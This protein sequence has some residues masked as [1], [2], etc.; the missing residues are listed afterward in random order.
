MNRKLIT[1]FFATLLALS[2]APVIAQPGPPGGAGGMAD[3]ARRSEMMVNMLAEQNGMD[4]KQ[5]AELKTIFDTALTSAKPLQD[6][7]QKTRVAIKDAVKA[8]KK[9]DE[10]NALH[11]QV[12][13]ANAK[14]AAVQSKAFGD[15]LHLLKD[16]QKENT[17]VIYEMI[18]MVSGGGGGRGAPM[19]RPGGGT[20]PRGAGA[21]GGATPKPDAPK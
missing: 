6:E 10:L 11:Q 2:S 17:D 15:V 12:G 3:P 14:L 9:Q 8:G 4:E 20:R 7:L 1:G 18:V 21:P 19:M 5:R 16:G 13:A